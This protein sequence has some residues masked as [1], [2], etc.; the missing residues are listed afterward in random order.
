MPT[1]ICKTCGVQYPESVDPPAH[2]LICEDERQYVPVSGQEWLTYADFVANHRNDVRV[3]EPNLLGIGVTPKFAIGQRALLVQTPQGNVLWDCVAL[4]DDE[5]RAKINTLGGVQTIALSHPH[6]YSA[7]VEWSRA[8]RDVPV[9]I[10]EHDRAWVTRPDPCIR[11]WQG[12]TLSL[13]DG[14][15]VINCGGHFE[16]SCVLHWRDSAEGKGVLLTG[17]SIYVVA[18]HR[19]V[20]FM[21]SYPNLIPLAATKIHQVATSVAGFAFDRIYAAWFDAMILHDAKQCVQRSA[22]RYIRAIS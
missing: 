4:I 2:C 22:E 18:D 9:Y 7:I 21:Y 19:Y 11:F 1:F 17:D 8:F 16:G 10:H 12:E 13:L 20:S 5:T 6:Y 15:T 3:E 14:V